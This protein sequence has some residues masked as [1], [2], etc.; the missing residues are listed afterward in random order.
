MTGRLDNNSTIE[1]SLARKKKYTKTNN[2][3]PSA[4]PLPIP[5]GDSPYV[6]AKRADYILKD[7]ELAKYFY[8]QA[9][10]QN[11]RA[12]SA[13]KDISSILHQQHRT[14]E[15]L[16]FLETHQYLF[17]AKSKYENLYNNLLKQQQ[18]TGNSLN[19][20]L[21]LSP[22]CALDT[23]KDIHSLFKNPN[24]IRELS[25]SEGCALLTFPSHSAARK[26][27]E[28]F[29]HWHQY[30]VEW[31]SLDGVIQGEAGYGYIMQRKYRTDE[32]AQLPTLTKEP[33]EN[34]AL[35]LLGKSLYEEI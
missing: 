10:N 3:S 16:R 5:K 2:T 28:G 33:S 30:K 15:A 22:V 32:A 20:I 31:M 29:F 17:T 18:P 34:T 8:M 27:L 11:E 14:E 9:I 7:L 19:R 26:T 24:R 13:V 21:R 23:V 4:L 35:L 12:E 6:R 1:L 25:L